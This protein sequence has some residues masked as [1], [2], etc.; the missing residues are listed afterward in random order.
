MVLIACD[1][2]PGVVRNYRGSELIAQH[3]TAVVSETE[4]AYY[5]VY[6]E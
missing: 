2:I 5:S 6:L 3:M 1:L 4:R